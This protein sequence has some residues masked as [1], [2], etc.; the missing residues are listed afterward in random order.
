VNN[1]QLT[2]TQKIKRAVVAATYKAEID[3]LYE[4]KK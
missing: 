2:S 3:R 1:G 4:R